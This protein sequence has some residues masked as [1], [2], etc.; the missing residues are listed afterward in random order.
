MKLRIGVIGLSHLGTC[1][2]IALALKGA[3]VLAFDFDAKIR[4]ERCLGYFDPAE[5]D[6][7]QF[8][9]K[10]ISNFRIANNIH[11]LEECNLLIYAKDTNFD[12]E[13]DLTLNLI[14][15]DIK[16]ISTNINNNAPLVIMSQVSP[17]FTRQFQNLKRDIVYQ[18]ETLIFGN[19]LDRALRPERIIFGKVNEEKDLPEVVQKFAELFNCTILEMSYESAELSKIAINILLSANITASNSLAE[20]ANYCGGNWRH[21]EQALRLDHRIGEF[22]YVSPGLGLGGTN[23]QRDINFASLFAE[24]M[25]INSIFFKSLTNHSLHMQNWI[26]R[27]INKI[28]QNKEKLDTITILGLAYKPGTQSTHGS[29]G[30][31]LLK[32]FDSNVKIFVHDPVVRL[33]IDEAFKNVSQIDDP[34][35]SLSDSDVIVVATNWP[36]YELLIEE[37]LKLG[38]I[39]KI[40]DPHRMIRATPSILDKCKLI[41]L[42]IYGK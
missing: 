10:P 6:I 40:L 16:F 18:V 11:E 20:L 21:I 42:G 7:M 25:G 15:N 24:K 13:K 34:L 1:Y 27:E 39:V 33:P 14:S 30:Y 36:E 2:S 9:Q 19:G 29:A 31:Q 26:V 17:G 3:N 28:L 12:L 23:L 4:N 8:L 35:M 22:A 32:I 41:Q 37:F 5:P 38:K